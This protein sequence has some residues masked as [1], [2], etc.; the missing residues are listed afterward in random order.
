MQYH[1]LGVV[2]QEQRQFE[3]AKAHYQ[4]ALQAHEDAGDFYS[5][6]YQY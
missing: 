3:Q 1:Q 5:T 6:S 2:A 4:K